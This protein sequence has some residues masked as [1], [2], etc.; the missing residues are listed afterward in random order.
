M[1][2]VRTEGAMAK[3]ID[4]SKQRPAD[5]VHEQIVDAAMDKI[6]RTG[7]ANIGLELKDFMPTAA[8]IAARRAAEAPAKV[9]KAP[10]APP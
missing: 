3:E 4:L 2:G 1:R 5:D 10:A 8:E 6:E 7:D 9:E